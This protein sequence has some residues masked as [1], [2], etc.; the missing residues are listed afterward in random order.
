V[1]KSERWE[2]I[3]IILSIFSLWPVIKW[4]NSSQNTPIYYHIFLGVILCVLGIITY[5]RIKRLRAALR[6]LK[7]KRESRPFPPFF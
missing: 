6:D 2:T 5:R 4:Y 1:R 3:I 7:A